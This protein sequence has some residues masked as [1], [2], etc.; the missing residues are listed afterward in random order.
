MSHDCTVRNCTQSQTVFQ[1][2]IRLKG[3]RTF[4]FVNLILQNENVQ[5][6]GN[7]SYNNVLLILLSNP[8]TKVTLITLPWDILLML[9][10]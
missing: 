9:D 2:H 1:S 8:F 6:Q 5:S 10:Q 4:Y 7:V 3:Y